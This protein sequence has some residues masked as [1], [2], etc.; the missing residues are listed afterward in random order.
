MIPIVLVVMGLLLASLFWRLGGD[1]YSYMRYMGVPILIAFIKFYLNDYNFIYFGYIILLYSSIKLFS[2]GVKAPI[3]KIWKWILGEGK[4]TEFWTRATCG[5]LWSLP[6]GL[7]A[8]LSGAWILFI[9][10]SALLTFGNGFIGAYV[11]DVEWSEKGVGLL[12]A[13]SLFI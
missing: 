1:G 8:Y 9:I 2:Y 6:A 10:Y 5:F 12:V 11:E 3:H 13:L 4:K 7:F